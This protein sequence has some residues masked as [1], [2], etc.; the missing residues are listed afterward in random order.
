MSSSPT[1]VRRSSLGTLLTG[2][3]LVAAYFLL[4]GLEVGKLGAE[5]D[6]GGGLLLLLGYVLTAVG[7][8]LVVRDL[9]HHRSSGH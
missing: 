7:V 6:I 2:V 8:V 1:P 3:L 9:L 5:T 4:S